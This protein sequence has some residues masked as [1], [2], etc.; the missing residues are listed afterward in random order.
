MKTTLV[1]IRPET[2]AL[3]D[4]VR[5]RLAT[6]AK[7]HACVWREC[8]ANMVL[9]VALGDWLEANPPKTK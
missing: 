7:T 3:I 8:S 4:Q 5:E 1:R 9:E 2:A 6:D